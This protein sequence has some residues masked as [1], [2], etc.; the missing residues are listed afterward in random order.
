MDTGIPSGRLLAVRG[1]GQS[2]GPALRDAIT[3]K[4]QPRVDRTKVSLDTFVAGT[5]TL[6][7]CA[8]AHGGAPGVASLDGDRMRSRKRHA[9]FGDVVRRVGCVRDMYLRARHG[10]DWTARD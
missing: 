10:D 2:T 8:S 4:A 3:S 6:V 5:D 7:Q 9:K 1:A